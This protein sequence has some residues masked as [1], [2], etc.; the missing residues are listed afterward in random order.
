MK[1]GR[2]YRIVSE[3][4]GKVYVGSTCQLLNKRFLEHKEKIKKTRME[5]YYKIKECLG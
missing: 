3:N 5:Y 2:V 1:K 4:G